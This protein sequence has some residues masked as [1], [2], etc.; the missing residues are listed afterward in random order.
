[1]NPTDSA[2]TR[3][4]FLGRCCAAV[5]YTGI[6]ST[7]AQLRAI[8]AVAGNNL[9][10]IRA[11]ALPPDY[12]ALVCLFLNG[13]ND[14]TN[15]VV[16]SDSAGY[17]AYARARGDL[18]LAQPGL[19]PIS[20]RR[21]ADGRSWALHPAVPALRDLFASGRLAV[22]CNVGTLVRPTTL[23]DYQAGKNLPP[24]LFSHSDQQLHW[25]SGVP[26][27]PFET[28][29]GGRLG[30]LV[31]ALNSSNDISLA[32]S[33][34]GSNSFQR[35]QSVFPYTVG[36]G[37]VQLMNFGPPTPTLGA[38][39]AALRGVF[40]AAPPNLLEAAF[41][42]I[43]TESL[44]DSEGLNSVLRTAPALGTRFPGSTTASQLAMVAKL[45]SVAPV[46]GLKRQIFFVELGGWDLH[47]AQAAG[48]GPL[49]AEISAAMKAFY[50]ATVELGIANQVTTF[51]TSDFGR[52]YVPNAGGTDHGWGNHQLIMGGAVQGGDFYGTMPSLTV[53]GNDDTGRGR[54]IPGTSVDEYSATLARWFGVSDTNL[55][56]VLPNIGR[57]AKPNLGFMG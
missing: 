9:D 50:D 22:L 12:K 8:G 32:I 17:A 44:N 49:L 21:Y 25:Q 10:R 4:R 24:Q 40:G 33:L 37:G 20:P 5:G 46:L 41:G 6:L 56:V 52:T 3:R 31:A 48:H 7:L 14:A 26:D 23:A 42:G 27:K 30:D 11:A 51:T 57:F 53:G 1:M 45:I 38:R 36:S 19:L 18:A 34:A 54:W 16:P 28:G 15:L 13:G 39:V 47:S 43:T 35:G 2:Y 55:P 29:W